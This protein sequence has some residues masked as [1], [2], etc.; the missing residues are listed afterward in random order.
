MD[1]SNG[2]SVVTPT[3]DASVLRVLTRTSRPL[4]GRQIAKLADRG[5]LRGIQLVLSRLVEQGIVVADV[6]PAIT[7]YVLNREHLAAGAVIELADLHSKL[8]ERLTLLC[9]A[10]KVAPR[11]V[12]LYGSAARRDGDASSDID[13]LLVSQGDEDS[14]DVWKEQADELAASIRAWT[15]NDPG[16]LDLSLATLERLRRNREPLWES[17]ERDNVLIFGEPLS[18]T[19]AETS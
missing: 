8:R 3:L 6:H 10:W 11:H 5:S 2:L 9:G 12:S 16:I 7:Q 14:S 13:V 19:V 4:S 1:I 15:G 18:R 17:V